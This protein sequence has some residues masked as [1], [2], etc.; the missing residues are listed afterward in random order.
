M[1]VKNYVHAHDT[2]SQFQ[3]DAMHYEEV[4]RYVAENREVVGD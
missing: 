1:V 2:F 4:K 3:S